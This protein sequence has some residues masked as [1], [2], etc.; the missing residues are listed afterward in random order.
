MWGIPSNCYPIAQ[1]IGGSHDRESWI[2]HYSRLTSRLAQALP[3]LACPHTSQAP[4]LAL[5]IPL[6][7]PKIGVVSSTTRRPHTP[8][9]AQFSRQPQTPRK[10]ISV[11]PL[12]LRWAGNLYSVLW[13]KGLAYTSTPSATFQHRSRLADRALP[14]R[15]SHHWPAVA[16]RLKASWRVLWAVHGSVGTASR[17][18]HSGTDFQTLG[19]T[20]RR[21]S[22]DPPAPETGEPPQTAPLG[23]TFPKD[24]CRSPCPLIPNILDLITYYKRD[25]SI[26]LLGFSVNCGRTRIPLH[27]ASKLRLRPIPC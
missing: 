16:E 21:N 10:Q 12:R 27:L 6:L 26:G 13:A 17:I 18:P 11:R 14:H 25:S 23:R 1:H 4:I 9:R 5:K 3:S 20:P 8:W 15:S 7:T 24:A 22:P 19:P 2:S